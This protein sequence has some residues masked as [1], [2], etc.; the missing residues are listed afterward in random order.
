MI[1]PLI[2]LPPGGVLTWAADAT[3]ARRSRAEMGAD[4]TADPGA[5]TPRMDPSRLTKLTDTLRPS[6][7]DGRRATAWRP[8]SGSARPPAA[9]MLSSSGCGCRF[10][11][12]ISSWP[13]STP[14]SR[15]G[16]R[17]SS[18][19]R[20]D[21][22]SQSAARWPGTT[23][24]RYAH[25]ERCAALFDA[26]GE[27][28]GRIQDGAPLT[29]APGSVTTGNQLASARGNSSRSGGSPWS[30]RTLTGARPRRRSR[31][32]GRVCSPSGSQRGRSRT[33]STRDRPEV[34]ASHF[35]RR[36]NS[37]VRRA[38]S[39]RRTG[40]PEDRRGPRGSAS[41]GV[42]P[43]CC[44]ATTVGTMTAGSSSGSRRRWSQSHRVLP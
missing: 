33:S 18:P 34:T 43:A 2:G 22:T 38:Q 17:P 16:P 12:T 42:R 35:A 13:G 20:T 29:L 25:P 9:S 21:A 19:F 24:R 4:T 5:R 40:C 41:D 39:E 6:H 11:S 1:P 32:P 23:C 26:A 3:F 44:V 8:R 14:A 37:P 30:P 15:T 36:L 7:S 27:R 31:R 10:T 28:T